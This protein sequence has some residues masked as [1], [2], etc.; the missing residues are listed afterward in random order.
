MLRLLQNNYITHYG[1]C[2]QFLINN[3]LLFIFFFLRQKE[4]KTP[5]GDF[6]F[7]L[8][9]PLKTTKGDLVSLWNPLLLRQPQDF[10]V[11]QRRRR[12][13]KRVV[14]TVWRCERVYQANSQTERALFWRR[15]NR[16][17]SVDVFC[18]NA[19]SQKGAL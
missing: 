16:P 3:K 2:L 11:P 14:A 12:T 13:Q 1:V 9:K 5:K 10:R 18:K 19:A 6:D 4:A 8:W 15:N 7:P 17:K